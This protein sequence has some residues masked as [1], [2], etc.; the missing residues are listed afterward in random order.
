MVWDGGTKDSIICC[1]VYT[2]SFTN[3]Q[4]SDWSP[5][6]WRSLYNQSWDYFYLYLASNRYFYISNDSS[7]DTKKKNPNRYR[8]KK[9]LKIITALPPTVRKGFSI[10]TKK[11]FQSSINRKDHFLE[12]IAFLRFK[13]IVNL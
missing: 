1:W 3:H 7:N 12:R 5:R 8:C 13:L 4:F 11:V 9:C 2:I 10:C 6:I